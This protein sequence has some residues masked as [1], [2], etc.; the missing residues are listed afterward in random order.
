MNRRVDLAKSIVRAINRHERQQLIRKWGQVSSIAL[1]D[2]ALISV[3][4]LIRGTLQFGN[5]FLRTCIT[6]HNFAYKASLL[7]RL[8]RAKTMSPI[9]YIRGSRRILF[10]SPC[11][12]PCVGKSTL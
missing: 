10:R 6:V 9:A 5:N 1:A 4:Y 11:A 2:D 7:I 12:M 8:D 3:L